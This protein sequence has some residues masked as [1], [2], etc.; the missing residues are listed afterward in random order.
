[1]NKC[2]ILIIVLII[3][4]IILVC[5]Y[6]KNK[7]DNFN[8]F[9]NINNK[10]IPNVIHKVIIQ[11]DSKLPTFPLEPKELQ[12]AHDSWKIKNPGYKIKY[13]SM[14]DCRN[15]LK[16]YFNSDHLQAF[17]CLKAYSY[18]C[19]LFRYCVLYNEGGWYSDWKQECLINNLLDKLKNEINEKIIIAWDKGRRYAELDKC[20]QTCFIGTSKNNVFLKEAINAVI[21]NVKYKNY[22]KSP[23][24]NTGP[25]LLGNLYKNKN[26]GVNNFEIHLSFK[27]VKDLKYIYYKNEKII[28]HKCKNCEQSQNWTDGNNYNK[29]W[30][31]KKIYND[32][33]ISEQSKFINYIS[34]EERINYYTNN[35]LY[36]KYIVNENNFLKTDKL[37]GPAKDFEPLILDKESLVLLYDPNKMSFITKFLNKILNIKEY[38]KCLI[39]VGDKNEHDIE[40]PIF[41]KVRNLKYFNNYSLLHPLYDRERHW[42]EVFN[43]NDTLN[44]NEKKNDV[45]WRGV[46]TGDLNSNYNTRIKFSKLYA[47]KYNIGISRFVQGIVPDKKIKKNN[48][49]INEMLKYKYIISLEGN[50]KD[51][52]LNWKLYS[53]SCVIMPKPTWESWLMEGKLIPWFHYIPL[54]DNID[55]LDEILEWCNKNQDKCEQISRN[56]TQYIHMFLNEENENKIINELFN[57]YRKSVEFL[58]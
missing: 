17:D 28:L 50:D 26:L 15:Y 40:L 22:D 9:N 56:S 41:A 36:K 27:T 54:N 12:E 25:G 30:K 32:C 53:N 34:N 13:Y 57:K 37:V 5:L 21:N 44:W 46:S 7:N 35:K 16:K 1:M 48:I 14:N 39:I 11:H 20:I 33:I 2:N 24:Y 47:N 45:I 3:I 42:K 8:E 23:I 6:C 55:N 18:K 10:N 49:T 29:L 51:S 52:G 31:D 38:T 43:L 4:I 19:D 58:K